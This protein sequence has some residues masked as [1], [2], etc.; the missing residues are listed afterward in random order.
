MTVLRDDRPIARKEHQ[1]NWCGE[2]I[3]VGEKHSYQVAVFDG[4]FQHT[5]MHLECDAAC[6][7]ELSGYD[8]WYD[9][10]GNRRGMT[11]D[12]AKEEYR[13]IP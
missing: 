2:M 11:S 10:F 9:P 5:R 8:G 1:C 13:R 3:L 6:D 7:R 4:D 12:E